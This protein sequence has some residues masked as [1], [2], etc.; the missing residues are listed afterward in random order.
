MSAREI[1]SG[2]ALGR[3]WGRLGL[4]AILVALMA[5]AHLSNVADSPATGSGGPATVAIVHRDGAISEAVMES[6]VREAVALAGGLDDV[7]SPG[8]VVVVKPNWVIDYGYDGDGITTRRGIVRAVVEMAQEA[9]GPTGDVYIA[10]GSAGEGRFCT[11]DA[12]RR[13][14]F[15]TYPYDNIDDATGAP[16]IDL[17]IAAANL[18]DPPDPAYVQEVPVDSFLDCIDSY[19]MPNIIMTCDVLI[20]VPCWK[21]H[22]YAGMTLACKNH[23]GCAPGDIYHSATSDCGKNKLHSCQAPYHI[24]DWMNRTIANLNLCRH[25]DFVVI[26]AL[27]GITDGP[28]GD[29]GPDYVSPEPQMVLAGRDFIAVDTIGTLLACYG[30]NTV[31]YLGMLEGRGLGTT[32]TSV[33]TVAGEHVADRRYVFPSW[34]SSYSGELVAPTVDGLLPA[35]GS[36]VYGTTTV[37]AVNPQDNVGVVKTEFCV[38]GE[39]RWTDTTAPF[40]FNWD[41]TQDAPGNHTV[42]AYVYDAM[43]SEAYADATYNVLDVDELTRS[44][45]AGWN[46]ISVAG[47]P[48]DPAVS[49]VLDGLTDAG[50][51]L[52]NSLFRY[53]PGSGYE[54]YPADFTVTD[55]AVGYWLHLTAEGSVL[56][57]GNE[58]VGDVVIPLADGWNLF[59]YPL[60]A[61]QSWPNCQVRLGAEVK[62]LPQAEDA[63]WVQGTIYYFGAGAYGTV[64]T[65]GSGDDDVLRAW[66]A[67]WM[68]ASMPGLEL[69]I[70]QP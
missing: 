59:G 56:Y 50:N 28:T 30:V 19:W 1:S 32:D 65:D 13:L 67:Y 57:L 8:D 44:F 66:R 20:D 33:I 9:T 38:D 35:G 51:D 42:T 14:G 39:L 60:A 3:R 34:G 36:D 63:G 24:W 53:A 62:T 64:A 29:G 15:D 27:R 18:D 4:S 55:V 21:N 16:L 46:M 2:R 23:I 37:E 11:V 69:I 26:D 17:N 49:V 61:V 31:E 43:L 54:V 12:F 47:V 48:L 70:P 5:A 58:V 7:I 41:T 45:D 22:G 52:T 40:T 6:M 68:L 25:A 10:E